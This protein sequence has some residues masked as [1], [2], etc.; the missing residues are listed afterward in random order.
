[1]ETW[2]NY[3]VPV[4]PVPG[5]NPTKKNLGMKGLNN[6]LKQCLKQEFKTT[7][8]DDIV[9]I[10]QHFKHNYHFKNGQS[11]IFGLIHLSVLLQY[12]RV[13]DGRTNGHT[14]TALSMYRASIASRGKNGCKIRTYFYRATLCQRGV[15]PC[16]SVYVRMAQVG[17]SISKRLNTDNSIK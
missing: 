11:D 14:K 7:C 2:K 5:I 9:C 16:L 6:C 15:L 17:C 1:M 3:P 12:R 10:L 13:T 4:N 8:N